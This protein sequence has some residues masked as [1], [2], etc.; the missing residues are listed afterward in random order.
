MELNAVTRSVGDIFSVN[1]KYLVPRFQREYSWT[2]E[3]VDE[4]WDDIIQQIKLDN[5]KKVKNEEYFIGC[6]VLVGED[7][8]QDYLIVD[9]QQRLATLTILLRAIVER[10]K[11]LHDE[12]AAKALY[13]NYIEGTDNDGKPYFKL[14]SESPKPYFQNEIQAYK[15]RARCQVFRYRT[16][17]A[18][19][20]EN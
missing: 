11:E 13:K 3:E 8:K 1:K 2:R 20:T 16:K 12:T 7:S 9:G 14:V 18:I 5:N 15:H 17:T 19:L 10:L 4:F 6:I